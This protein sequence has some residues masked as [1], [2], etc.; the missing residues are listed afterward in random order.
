ML[1]RTRPLAVIDTETTGVNVTKDRIIEVAVVRIEL[2]GTRTRRVRR[3]NPECPIPPE[4]TAV[5]GIA[6]ADVADEPP[7][8]QVAKGL[9]QLLEGCDI[10]GFNV[11]AF[12]V[13]LLHEEFARAGITWDVDT[14]RILDAGVLYKVMEPRTLAAAV[15][16]YLGREHVGAHGALAD[17]EATADVIEAQATRYARFQGEDAETQ[18]FLASRYDGPPS[19]DVGGKLTRDNDGDLVYAFGKENGTKVRANMGYARWMLRSDFPSH[20]CQLLRDEI[21]RV[22]GRP[23]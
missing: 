12:D 6:D 23:A 8:R 18:L 11:I 10:A 14:A 2:D 13:P 16:A 7:F 3:V 22:T 4:A 5:H 17:T 21:Q 19:A 15:I 9:H 20:T 1:P